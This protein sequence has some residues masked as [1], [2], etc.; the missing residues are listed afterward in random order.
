MFLSRDRLGVR[1]LFYASTGRGLV[2]ASEIKALFAH[3]EVPRGLDLRGL[4][5][6]V[7]FWCTLAPRTAFRGVQELPRG[8]R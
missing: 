7:T 6:I 4:D 3:P 2:F 1:P 8:T 5:E